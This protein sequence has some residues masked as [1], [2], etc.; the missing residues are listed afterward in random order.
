MRVTDAGSVADAEGVRRDGV[1]EAVPRDA[2]RVGGDGDGDVEAWRERDGPTE[3]VAD[4]VRGAVGVRGVRVAVAALAVGPLR[5][6]VRALAVALG[7]ALAVREAVMAR[8]PVMVGTVADV[9]GAVVLTLGVGTVGDA[10]LV[11]DTVGTRVL[12]RVAADRVAADRDAL[13]VPPVP[14]AVPEGVAVRDAEGDRWG[15]AVGLVVAAEPVDVADDVAVDVGS[16]E[17]VEVR[18]AQER[19]LGTVRADLLSG[20]SAA[21]A[22]RSPASIFV[23]FHTLAH[24]TMVQLVPRL[25]FAAMLVPSLSA[26]PVNCVAL[27]VAIM[28]GTVV[29]TPV[30]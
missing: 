5:D 12:L 27:K 29:G 3:A 28:G 2:V 13:G 19:G 22:R 24:P 4:G 11:A 30:V 15:V 8:E 25:G 20:H 17:G 26:Y 23:P 21:V 9:V 10:V 7:P 6:P 14:V 1:A 18:V 16:G